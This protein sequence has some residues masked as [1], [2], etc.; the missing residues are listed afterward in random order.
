[1]VNFSIIFKNIKIINLSFDIDDYKSDFHKKNFQ[2]LKK[3]LHLTNI[4]NINI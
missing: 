3:I 2:E 4:E 1:L